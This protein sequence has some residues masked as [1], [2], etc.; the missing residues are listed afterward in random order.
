MNST[1]T[2]FSEFEP[3]SYK[4]WR[5]HFVRATKGKDTEQCTRCEDGAITIEP[6]YCSENPG[7]AFRYGSISSGSTATTKLAFEYSAQELLVLSPDSL[8]SMGYESGY[9]ELSSEAEAGV[10]H[11]WQSATTFAHLVMFARSA[12][13]ANAASANNHA[14]IIDP[15]LHCDESGVLSHSWWVKRS[16]ATDPCA[17]IDMR[18]LQECG[19]NRTFQIGVAVAHLL[20]QFRFGLQHGVAPEQ[21]LRTS[22]V[23]FAASSELVLSA[24]C[25]PAFEVLLGQ[26]INELGIANHRHLPWLGDVSSS[27]FSRLSPENNILRSTVGVMAMCLAGCDS[28]VVPEHLA[29]VNDG[30]AHTNAERTARSQMLLLKHE[31][32]VLKAAQAL[33][34]SWFAEHLMSELVQGGASW[35]RQIESIGGLA[36]ALSSGWIAEQIT[37]QHKAT[38]EAVLMGDKKLVGVNCYI[39]ESQV[40]ANRK[41]TDSDSLPLRAAGSRADLK[42]R[43][44]AFESECM[45]LTGDKQ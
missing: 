30:V 39:D 29:V 40:E 31:A 32:Q 8:L 17:C 11:D 12:E 24:G 42:P 2:K 38:A 15:F 34:G 6:L 13:V 36:A 37:I 5:E 27:H 41:N 7:S 43:R 25:K 18:L 19:A 4:A 16:K 21:I 23:R 44:L 45:A 10:L 28:V 20:D 26:I 14:L 22:I 35:L 9:V 3:H 1:G 33:R